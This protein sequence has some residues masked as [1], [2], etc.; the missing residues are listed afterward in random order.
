MD[1]KFN[2]EMDQY[3]EDEYEAD[4]EFDTKTFAKIFLFA[5]AYVIGAVTVALILMPR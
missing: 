5:A 3:L 2:E 1:D 4:N